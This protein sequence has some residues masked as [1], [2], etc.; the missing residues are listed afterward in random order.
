MV[1]NN[2]TARAKMIQIDAMI[3]YIDEHQ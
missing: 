3:N 2:G 1:L